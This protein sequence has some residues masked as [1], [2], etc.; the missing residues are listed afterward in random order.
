MNNIQAHEFKKFLRE[1]LEIT[2]EFNGQHGS[3]NAQSIG[4]RFK[5]DKEC[6]TEETVFIPDDN[7]E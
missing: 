6:F 7:G 3:S 5:G 1:H 2:V 4:L